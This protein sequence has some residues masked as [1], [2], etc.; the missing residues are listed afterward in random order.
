MANGTILPP[1]LLRVMEMLVR[2]PQLVL[3]YVSPLQFA[4][5]PAKMVT[6]Q[7]PPPTVFA[8]MLEAAKKQHRTAASKIF[9]VV[10]IYVKTSVKDS[11]FPKRVDSQSV[12]ISKAVPIIPETLSVSIVL[13]LETGQ[14]CTITPDTSPPETPRGPTHPYNCR[15]KAPEAGRNMTAKGEN[16]TQEILRDQGRQRNEKT[17]GRMTTGIGTGAW[18]GITGTLQ[19]T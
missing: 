6:L 10:D 2:V 16:E 12:W 5:P 3:K 4:V 15:E 17:R 14:F 18:A 9:L 11:G 19:I 7:D 8:N 1:T 13:T